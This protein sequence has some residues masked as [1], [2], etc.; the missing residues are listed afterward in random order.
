MVK[1]LEG[2]LM[3]HL[4][5]YGRRSLHRDQYAFLPHFSIDLCKRLLFRTVGER[6]RKGQSTIAL[7]VDFRSAYDRVDRRILTELFQANA[8]L[9]PE[10]LKLLDFLLSSLEVHYGRKSTTSTNGVPQGLTFFPILFD[11]YT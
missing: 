6:R 4:R 9:S 5:H 8:V 10:G 1:F 11:L 2:W 3:P 7:F